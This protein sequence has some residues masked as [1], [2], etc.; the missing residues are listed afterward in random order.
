MDR[1]ES[2]FYSGSVPKVLQKIIKPLITGLI[3][4]TSLH[5]YVVIEI[6]DKQKAL[7]PLIENWENN[8]N[9]G[10]GIFK[11]FI[12]VAGVYISISNSNK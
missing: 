6:L 12:T 9:V 5:F 1:K 10:K 11:R 7:A 3:Q 2:W 4:I 8:L